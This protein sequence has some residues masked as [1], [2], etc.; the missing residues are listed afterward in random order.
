MDTT[1]KLRKLQ[2]LRTECLQRQAKN[3]RCLQRFRRWIDSMKLTDDQYGLIDEEGVKRVWKFACRR[4]KLHNN[5]PMDD[6]SDVWIPNQL[7]AMGL[8]LAEDEPTWENALRIV[9][10]AIAETEN[11][12]A[13]LH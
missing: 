5:E 7:S 13:G 11:A 6:L 12:S 1:A 3:Q 10:K 8:S 9:D 4:L 2:D